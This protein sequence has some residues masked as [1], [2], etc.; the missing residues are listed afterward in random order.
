[1]S[2]AASRL[3]R[4]AAAPIAAVAAAILLVVLALGGLHYVSTRA[5]PAGAARRAGMLDGR[6]GA[7]RQ[8]G[9]PA[10]AGGLG[11]GAALPPSQAALLVTRDFGSRALIDASAPVAGVPTVLDL[12]SRNADI[13][14][15]YGGGFVSSIDGLASGGTRGGAAGGDWFYYVNGIRG[16]YGSGQYRLAGRDRVWWDFH[17]WDFALS[18]PAAVGQFPEPFVRGYEG[19]ALTTTIAF[20]PGFEA[21]ARRIAGALKKAGAP[22]VTTVPL[23][24]GLA[25]PRND[26]LMLVGRWPDVAPVPWV[27]D[28][29]RHPSTSGLFARFGRAGVDALDGSGRIARTERA[30]GAVMATARGDAPGAAI[31]LVTGSDAADVSAAAALLTSRPGEL[32]SKFGALVDRTG[33]VTALPVPENGR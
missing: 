4:L 26:H 32:L 28:A 12:L 10:V 30:A 33:G 7:A 21:L 14:T 23:G 18:V 19:K 3:P 1:M 16:T 20:G 2:G 17:R 29:A 27:R 13:Q 31:W 22:Q 11:S 24:P 6:G 5:R 15:A 25:P 8:V 9:M